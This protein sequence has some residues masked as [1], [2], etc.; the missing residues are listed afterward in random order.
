MINY[1]RYFKYLLSAI[2]VSVLLILAS[3]ANGQ[4]TNPLISVLSCIFSVFYVP[5]VVIKLP[6]FNKYY[7]KDSLN[8]NSTHHTYANWKVA[9]VMTGLVTA[10]TLSLIFFLFKIDSIG[11]HSVLGGAFAAIISIYY[12]PSF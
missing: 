9:P 12:E 7:I 6:V 3:A 8:I 11:Y 10:I 2:T 4:K 1:T 5:L